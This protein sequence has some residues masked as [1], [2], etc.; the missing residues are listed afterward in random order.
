MKLAASLARNVQVPTSRQS[1]GGELRTTES[2]GDE[3][4]EDMLA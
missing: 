3:S 4:R 1:A 2:F